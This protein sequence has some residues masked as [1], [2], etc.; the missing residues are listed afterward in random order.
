MKK[1]RAQIGLIGLGV[2]GE[3]LILNMADHGYSVAVYNRTQSKAD[4]FFKT[5]AKGKSIIPAKTLQDFVFALA[6]PRKIILMIKAGTAIDELI[7]QL[8]PYVENG[9]IFIDGGNSFFKDTIRRTAYVEEKGFRYIGM[10][11]SGGEQGARYGPSL[12]PGGSASAWQEIKEIFQAISAKVGPQKDIPCCDW[13]G[14]GGAGHFVKMVH[15]GIEYADLQLIAESYFLMKTLLGMRPNEIQS[16]FADWNSGILDSYLIEITAAILE[17]KDPQT[18][19]YLV[20]MIL[21]T[22]GQKG[23][24]ILTSQNALELGVPAPT[25]IEATVARSLSSLKNERI[26]ARRILGA[27]LS[28]TAKVTREEFLPQIHDALYAAKILSYAQGFAL[29]RAASDEYQWK[30][31]YG[32]IAYLWRGGCI[33]RARFLEEIKRAYDQQSGD[34]ENFM[35]APYFSKS[36]KKQE[37]HLR[38]VVCTALKAGVPVPAFASSLTYYDAYRSDILPANLIQALRDFFGAHT[39]QRIDMPGSFHTEWNTD[40]KND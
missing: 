40:E 38:T 2:M 23:T 20:D 19:A 3:N 16:V 6:K 13:I 10:G 22:A 9:D 35:F 36:L 17:K 34:S 28:E 18:D 32:R 39:Y 30:L 25:L 1:N 31:D 7:E 29:L 4:E 12:M 26:K 15:N 5:K 24:G 37:P 33:I 14:S 11:V 8:L 27:P 21:D